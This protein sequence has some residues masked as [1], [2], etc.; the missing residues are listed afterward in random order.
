MSAIETLIASPPCSTRSPTNTPACTG[1]RDTAMT[2]LLT[3]TDEDSPRSR[4]SSPRREAMNYNSNSRDR[5]DRYGP[6]RPNGSTSGRSSLG[7]GQVWCR[8]ESPYTSMGSSYQQQASYFNG[9]YDPRS[10][11]MTDGYSVP[12]TPRNRGNSVMNEDSPVPLSTI[13]PGWAYPTPEQLDTAYAYAIRRPDGQYTRLIPADTIVDFDLATI[14]RRQASAE[15]LI[16]LPPPRAL[17]PSLRQG[18]EIM[19]SRE[20][21]SL[22][23]SSSN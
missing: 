19:I 14:Q 16:I 2:C 7:S 21:C 9:A 8:D 17:E 5:G 6:A 15:N 12:P 22:N 3:S 13:V 11:M 20:V 4:S 1:F 10:P 23:I 18:S